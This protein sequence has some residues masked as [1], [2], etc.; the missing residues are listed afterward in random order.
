MFYSEE[1]CA[2]FSPE[3]NILGYWTSAFLDLWIT[4][5][6]VWQFITICS[7]HYSHF[8]N[9][10][11]HHKTY[12]TMHH[13]VAE[14]CTRVH[15]SVTKWHIVGYETGVFWNLCNRSIPNCVVH[16]AIHSKTIQSDNTLRLRQNGHHFGN[17][18]S[19]KFS[20]IEIVVFQFEFLRK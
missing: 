11:M 10:T 4:S 7:K 6:G 2:H 16:D 13:F 1:K 19:N 9:T 18:I 5:I 3:C 15:T 14:M 12:P 17:D 8:T 20:W